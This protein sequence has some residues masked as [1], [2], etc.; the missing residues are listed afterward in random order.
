M[1]VLQ[2]IPALSAGGAEGFITNLCIALAELGVEVHVFLLVGVRGVRGHAQL[3]RLRE[4]GVEVIGIEERKA[5]SLTNLLRL[6]WLI[7]SWKPHVV[8]ANLYAA[9][10]A[11]A[12]ASILSMKRGITYVHRL[13]NTI[14][15]GSRT[16]WILRML[17]KFFR[18]TIA[19]SPVV[20]KAYREFMKRAV[21]DKIV[22]IPNGVNMLNSIPCAEEKRHARQLLGISDNC[23]VVAHVGRIATGGEARKELCRGLATSQKAHDILL[24]AFAQAFDKESACVMLCVGDGNLRVDAEE[25]AR[26]LGIENDVRFLGEVPEPWTVL[27]ATDVF[28]FPSRFE[29][30]PNALVEAAAHGL[31]VVASDI[32]EIQYLSPG[33]AWLTIP[34]DDVSRFAA[35][36]RVVRNEIEDYTRIAFVEA[37]MYR[38]KFAIKTCGEKYIKAYEFAIG[39]NKV[40]P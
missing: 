33:K 24:K 21:D 40:K 37:Q 23:F 28:F 34:V 31:P 6:T 9:K 17:D 3:V 5:A 27:K 2:V 36:L 8:H 30:L 13:E 10:I 39:C 25:L 4:A 18:I 29:G 19:I 15:C 16:A 14:V 35:A 20:A 12:C 11:C 22:I 1:K 26:K 38:R 32:P 7:R